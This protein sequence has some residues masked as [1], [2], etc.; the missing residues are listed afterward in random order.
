MKKYAFIVILITIFAPLPLKE[1]FAFAAPIQYAEWRNSFDSRGAIDS[2]RSTIHW[3]RGYVTLPTENSGYTLSGVLWT[4]EIGFRQDIYSLTLSGVY[5]KP[6]G[7]T[8]MGSVSFGK[9]I[10]EYPLTWGDAFYSKD[11]VRSVRLKIFLATSDPNITPRLDELYLR[12]ELQDRSPNGPTNRDNQRVSDLKRMKGVINRYY[13]DFNIYPV[14]NVN[15]NSKLDQWRLLRGVL[16]SASTTYFKNYSSGF[17]NQPTGVDDEYKYGYLT[18]SSGSQ[19][20]FWVQLEDINS[21]QFKDS[22]SGKWS[23][24]SCQP[25]VYCLSN[26]PAQATLEQVPL[27]GNQNNSSAEISFA[28]LAP[29]FIKKENDAKVWLQ[30]G[31]YRV[32]LRNPDIFKKAGGV[33]QSIVSLSDLDSISPFKL[34]K[35]ENN[36]V[37]YMV[38][39]N[40]F[41]RRLSDRVPVEIYGKSSEAVTISDK[42]ISALPDN[43]LIR[44][45]GDVKVY[46]LDQNIKRWITSP[47]V[48]KKSGFSFSQVAEVDPRE[49]NYYSESESIY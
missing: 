4:N 14:V 29:V 13:K 24:V 45:Q 10:V 2:T 25:P 35:G 22:W 32:W 38:T 48:L 18:N 41:K 39:D 7:T 33:W 11:R 37:V 30:L 19:Y 28:G 46:L 1:L 20:L 17:V 47:D 34:V 27:I 36:P 40:G 8:L 31:N 44:A 3:E 26:V 15:V 6:D 43:R 9:D 21:R 23:D 49:L 42:I 16:D 5:D 12:L